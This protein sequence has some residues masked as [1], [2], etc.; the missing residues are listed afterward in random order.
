[1]HKSAMDGRRFAPER[2]AFTEDGSTWDRHGRRIHVPKGIASR[3]CHVRSRGA[4]RRLE[5]SHGL[6]GPRGLP[7][8]LPERCRDS[9]AP[10]AVCRASFRPGGHVLPER[11]VVDSLTHTTEHPTC[12]GH[13][14]LS[15]TPLPAMPPCRPTHR[16]PLLRSMW[17]NLPV[18]TTEMCHLGAQV[19]THRPLCSQ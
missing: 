11:C 17:L 19:H 16:A 18:C 7:L 10:G 15:A 13:R 1:M 12:L 5:G 14:P 6:V 2:N 4:D 8:R 3:S 9:G